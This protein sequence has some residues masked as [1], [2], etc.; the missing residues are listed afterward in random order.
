MNY[1]ARPGADQRKLLIP[2]IGSGELAGIDLALK[3]KQKSPDQIHHFS[4]T[5]GSVFQDALL[6]RGCTMATGAD[7]NDRRAEEGTRYVLQKKIKKHNP[8]CT[9]QET[10]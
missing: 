6:L 8:T 2:N 10:T 1:S 5:T 4:N 7:R 9:K 3:D